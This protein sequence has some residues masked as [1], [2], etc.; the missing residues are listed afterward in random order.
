MYLSPDEPVF[1][2]TKVKLFKKGNQSARNMTLSK[3][4][5]LWEGQVHGVIRYT[6]Y[7]EDQALLEIEPLLTV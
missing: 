5:F 6:L 7:L 3:K 4:I 1:P 2:S